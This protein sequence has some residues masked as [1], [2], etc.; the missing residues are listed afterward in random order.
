MHI[1]SATYIALQAMGVARKRRYGTRSKHCDVIGNVPNFEHH[2][3]IFAC[4]YKTKSTLEIPLYL[5]DP[6]PRQAL[7]WKLATYYLQSHTNAARL[8]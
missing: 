2:F 5:N 4:K 1:K 6:V 8:S 3:D 7:L